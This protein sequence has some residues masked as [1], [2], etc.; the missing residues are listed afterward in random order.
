MDRPSD[1]YV[2]IA[3]P[4]DPVWVDHA[5]ALRG[6]RTGLRM[7]VAGLLGLAVLC[8]SAPPAM[9][10]AAPLLMMAGMVGAHAR[11][12][13]RVVE[14]GGEPALVHMARAQQRSLVAAALLGLA[15]FFFS[16]V[17]RG[18]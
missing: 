12:I 5:R 6:A 2:A 10:F 18:M 13:T 16:I 7:T 8:L 1:P 9:L 15:G 3:D 17:V 11:A 4:D 14:G